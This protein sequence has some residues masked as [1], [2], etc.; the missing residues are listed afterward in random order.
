M[1]RYI[2]KKFSLKQFS[3]LAIIVFFVFLIVLFSSNILNP[4]DVRTEYSVVNTNDVN[5]QVYLRD[6]NFI[7]Q[8]YLG[9]DQSYITSLVDY[10][11]ISFKQNVRL[12]PFVDTFYDYTVYA[13]LSATYQN[14]D[15]VVTD[16]WNQVYPLK[17]QNRTQA[18]NNFTIDEQVTIPLQDYQNVVTSFQ[19]SFRLNIDAKL[20]VVLE[21]HYLYDNTN[22]KN[23][24]LT[25]TI[26]M[27]QDVFQISADYEKEDTFAQEETISNMKMNS[28]IV[29]FILVL[30]GILEACLL[31]IIFIKLVPI[32]SRNIYEKKKARIKKDYSTIIVD[33]NNPIDFSKFTIFEIKTIEELV[34]LEEE[35]RIPILSYEKKKERV[36]YFVIIKDKYMYR[37]TLED[38]ETEI[39]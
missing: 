4:T 19:D 1:I 3:I 29:V 15:G 31:F 26:P 22:I 25:V 34:D 33:V 37:Y 30:I 20:E 10:I 39:L 9:M 11:N 12:Q 16:I 24:Q 2:A 8:S 18:N 7:N 6:N 13:R 27:N 35:V 23:S 32:H 21:A 14:E 17:V 38:L 28:S 36:C 5:Y